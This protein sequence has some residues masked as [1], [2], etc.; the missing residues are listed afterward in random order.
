MPIL[1]TWDVMTGRKRDG[2]ARRLEGAGAL[3]PL[4]LC[5]LCV[6]LLVCKATAGELKPLTQLVHDKWDS[7]N[8][9][10]QNSVIALAQT[11]DGYLWFGTE[12]GL[13][14]FDGV[15]FATFG[16]D[17]LNGLASETITALLADRDGS[18]WVGTNGGGLAHL[19][20]GKVSVFSSK[21]GLPSDSISCLY[22]DAAGTIWMGTDGAGVLSYE[23]GHFHAYTKRDGLADNAVFALSGSASAGLWIGTHAG[24]SNLRH[25]HMQSGPTSNDHSPMDIRSILVDRAGNTW[26]GSNGNGL[27]QITSRGLVPV[28]AAGEL[29]RSALWS[30]RQD[31]A[32]AIWIGT[33]RGELGRLANGKLETLSED[34]GLTGSGVWSLLE[35]R[36]GNLWVGETGSG[37]HRFKNGAFS[38]LTQ[39]N[40][41]ASKIALPVF[42]DST[43]ALWVGSDEGLARW[44]NGTSQIFTTA[45]GLGN[46]VVFSLAEDQ[47]KTLWVGT[48]KGLFTR[49]ID[50]SSPFIRQSFLDSEIIHALYADPHGTMWIGGRNGL[51]RYDR[52]SSRTY[53][54]RDG[55]SNDNV[56]CIYQD[57]G[58]VTW[59]GTAG[60]GLNRLEGSHFT[61]YTSHE[62]LS[63][64]VVWAITGEPDGTLWLATNGGGL[65]RIK[66][67]VITS[68]SSQQGLFYD[69]IF[70]LLDDGKGSLWM[71]SNKGVARVQ[72]DQ[73]N[74]LAEGRLKKIRSMVFGTSDGMPS[75]ECNG[76]FQPSSCRTRDGRL[77]FPTV[78][79]VAVADPARLRSSSRPPSAL[80]ETIVTP[81]K[82]YLA[83]SPLVIPP[84]HT[85]LEVHFTAIN[86][87]SPE[88]VRFRY[89]LEGLDKEW[90]TS[91]KRRTAYYTN[92]PPGDYHFKVAAST[93]GEVW[94][95]PTTVSLS[96]QPHFYQTTWFAVAA[97]IL[98][99]GLCISGYRIRVNGLKKNERRLTKLKEAAE[100]ANHAKSDFLANMS[101]E[102]RTPINGILGMTDL[103]LS[104]DL[105]DEQREYLDIV[106]LSADSLIKIVNDILDFSKIEARKLSLDSHEFSLLKLV[107]DVRKSLAY[108]ASQKNIALAMNISDDVPD[109]V[110]SDLGRLKQVLIIL[111]DNA[112]KFTSKGQVVLSLS[113]GTTSQFELELRCSVSDTGIGIPTESLALIFEPFSQA[114]NSSTRKF[115]GTGLG[116]TI[117]SQLVGLMGGRIWAESELGRGSTFHFTVLV[118]LP[119]PSATPCVQ[120]VGTT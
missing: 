63:N 105:T 92:V 34:D 86:L 74:A 120:Q 60:G 49:K 113:L 21:T 8:G 89:M 38:S 54:T 95:E 33:G 78:L 69:S 53:T 48:R 94:S 109:C 68:I 13:V 84:G 15:H 64:D 102:I 96:M 45:D 88:K 87:S 101:H 77:L 119:Q 82:E 40:G 41:L 44:K 37:L 67:G 56:L 27:W 46:N 16:K 1:F 70:G 26:V 83:D 39:R 36:E 93:D 59:V 47:G 58:G 115:G 66:N 31:R 22:Q 118:S 52:A 62:G 42:E 97:V 76:S 100:A 116:L 28:A 65:N 80:I 2:A 4:A 75:A 50:G 72:I 73:L 43:G 79:G 99:A 19:H 35:D 23:N 18:L 7:S 5:L 51:T 71:T 30:L 98:F 14:R 108:R 32:G 9:L 106:K 110:V 85:K 114:D 91:G 107:E 25:G 117:C 111:L 55:L 17:Q 12:L 11:T 57:H 103:T 24:L 29:S 90:T 6:A 10:P 20:S 3:W 61:T 104:T 112:I 81:D